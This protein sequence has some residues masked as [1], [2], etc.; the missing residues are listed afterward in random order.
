MI[1]Q[2]IVNIYWPPEGHERHGRGYNY[3]VLAATA[4]DAW[5]RVE[6]RW[7]GKTGGAKPHTT[8]VL[9]VVDIDLFELGQLP[10]ELK[11]D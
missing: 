11:V 1:R 7:S 10:E 3:L 2:F 6:A 9:G 5:A 8:Q 4:E